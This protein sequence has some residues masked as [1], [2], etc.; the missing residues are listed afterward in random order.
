M[1]ISVKRLFTQSVGCGVEPQKARQDE[2]YGANGGGD[3]QD[4]GNLLG[5]LML[6]LRWN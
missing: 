3:T 2:A 4:L 5:G 6:D 1:D